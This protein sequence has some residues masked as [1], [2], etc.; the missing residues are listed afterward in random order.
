VS[1]RRSRSNAP[2]QLC[3]SYAHNLAR[4]GLRYGLAN[5]AL[6]AARTGH[7]KNSGSAQ[8][9]IP[10]LVRQFACRNHEC[11]EAKLKS[12]TRARAG[13]LRTAL[14]S[15]EPLG[16]PRQVTSLSPETLRWIA[17]TVRRYRRVRGGSLP[18][19][20]P[21]CSREAANSRKLPLGT[22]ALIAGLS[23]VAIVSFAAVSSGSGEQMVF[24]WGQTAQSPQSPPPFV[25]TGPQR[26]RTKA[27][28]HRLGVP[29]H[30]A[31][32]EEPLNTASIL[33]ARR[34]PSTVVVASLAPKQSLA[35]ITTVPNTP[36]KAPERS[37]ALQPPAA[38]VRPTLSGAEATAYLAR[39]ETALRNGDVVG[40]RSLFSRLAEAGDPRGALGM[41]R[42]YDPAEFKKLVVYG[43]KPDGAE[44]ERWRARAREL[45]SAIQRDQGSSAR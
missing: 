37:A 13:A 17:R 34:V 44:S 30:G 45:A 38:Q 7:G 32:P 40:A 23:L 41:A 3:A 36:V 22:L 42:S 33:P 31:I 8:L 11:G 18:R 2:V 19:L 28:E 9:P 12:E 39:A 29:G 4:I 43:L 10:A 15:P 1:L 25:D 35:S 27:D 6:A 14:A 20:E 26:V 16:D 24:R 21:T 5:L